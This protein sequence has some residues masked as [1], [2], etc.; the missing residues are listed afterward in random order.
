MG[1]EIFAC[2]PCSLKFELNFNCR[3]MNNRHDL[4][5]AEQY[6]LVRSLSLLQKVCEISK[7]TIRY[8]ADFRD[9]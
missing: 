3:A 2:H 4:R 6:A 1:Q 7:K 9:F 8:L 5:Y